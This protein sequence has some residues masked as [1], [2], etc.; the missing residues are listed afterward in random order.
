MHNGS[1][2]NEII[3]EYENGYKEKKQIGVSDWWMGVPHFGEDVVIK[4]PYHNE[5]GNKKEPLVA[6]YAVRVKLKRN[7]RLKRIVFPMN[8]RL[9][10]FAL[11]LN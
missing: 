9:H 10:I 4:C 3:F 7:F 2:I 11:T 8:D 1:E 6:M 5:V